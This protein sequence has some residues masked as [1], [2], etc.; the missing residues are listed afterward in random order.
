MGFRKKSASVLLGVMAL[1]FSSQMLVSAVDETSNFENKTL[2]AVSNDSIKDDDPLAQDSKSENEGS[3][4]SVDN[5]NKDVD[6]QNLSEDK[7]DKGFLYVNVLPKNEDKSSL[8]ENSK[9]A[10][11]TIV[12]LAGAKTTADIGCVVKE[13][14][15]DKENNQNQEQQDNDKKE[16]NEE[17]N[18][19]DSGNSDI[20]DNNEVSPQDPNQEQQDD[21]KKED[22]DKNNNQD[23]DNSDV[24]D[25]NEVS[26]QDPTLE[27]QESNS[28][29][30][31][32][33]K[34]LKVLYFLT[35]AIRLYVLYHDYDELRILF[36]E[37]RSNFFG[38]TYRFKFWG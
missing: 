4:L 36:E 27:K 10:L 14:V 24:A 20:A 35:I 18:N 34:V 17:N 28:G 7:T 21:D 37:P 33:I 30:V 8:I 9:T 31:M 1:G 6:S 5:T 3:C 29:N 38:N 13:F 12:G 32:L 25:N 2:M 23:S 16:E 11:G 19:Q 26:P 15:V 22:K